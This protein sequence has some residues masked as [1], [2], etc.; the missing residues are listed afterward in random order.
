MKAYPFRDSAVKVC[1]NCLKSKQLGEFYAHPAMKDGHVNK[2]KSCQKERIANYRKKNLDKVRARDRLRGRTEER[3]EKNK[4]RGRIKAKEYAPYKEKWRKLNPAKI[5]AHSKLRWAIKSKRL[6]R[7]P[8][9]ICGVSKSEAHHDD[10]AQP[11]KVRW[12]CRRHHAEAHRK[13]RE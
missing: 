2:C 11:L 10:Y 4:I 7:E 1:R 12:L 3:L 8:C 9:E 5:K 6:Q 13:Y